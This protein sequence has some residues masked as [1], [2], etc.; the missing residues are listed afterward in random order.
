MSEH[1][2]YDAVIIGAGISGLV[3]GCYLAK[4]GLKTL[5]VEK[6]AN[7][8]GYCTSFTFNGFR[9]DACAHALSSLRKDARLYDILRDLD[10][11]LKIKRP[12]PSEQIITP[13]FK[14]N[15]YHEI[16]RTIAEFQRIFS[17][18]EREIEN[19]FKHVLLGSLRDSMA[20]RSLTFNDLLERYFKDRKLKSIFSIILFRLLGVHS[21]D[22]SATVGI[23]IWREFIFDG[24]YYPV[25]G[26]QALP[27]CLVAK[28]KE[29]GGKV[30]FNHE[31]K[32]LKISKNI[33]TNIFIENR[34]PINS[35]FVIS[36]CDFKETYFA[37]LKGN[38]NCPIN[39]KKNLKKRISTSS[40]MVYLGLELL[41]E[42]IGRTFLPNIYFINNLDDKGNYKD[43]LNFSNS[44]A[45]VT[46][47]VREDYEKKENI[48]LCIGTNASYE[49][50]NFWNCENKNKFSKALLSLASQFLPLSSTRIKTKLEASPN[51]MFRWTYNYKGSSYGWASTI[52]HFG[53]P[54]F[55]QRTTIENLFLTGHWCNQGSGVA[56]V[57]SCGY[58]TA[59]SILSLSK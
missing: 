30:N 16:M 13:E 38:N 23:I 54:D 44:H 21:S 27:E 2:D 47:N 5:I 34:D 49:N 51:T 56:F 43:F 12:N 59:N 15:I 36:A 19:F 40:F 24:G 46:S 4:A 10:I 9:F 8:G 45:T 37:F 31:V 58:D 7:P 35:K 42:E 53:D 41:S 50:D 20:F 25:G 52:K 26:M 3:C 22:I 33:V 29:F 14:I 11:N 17:S 57:A 48:S 28:F 6:N 18:E 32:K 39:F 1:Y 55:S